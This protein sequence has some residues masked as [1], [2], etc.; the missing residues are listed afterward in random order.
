MAP[1]RRFPRSKP[2]L[3]LAKA[4]PASDGSSASV[5]MYLR[6]GNAAMERELFLSNPRE[7]Q[8]DDLHAPEESPKCRCVLK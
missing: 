6:G 8:E 5:M 1:L 4:E 7:I 2:D 3:P